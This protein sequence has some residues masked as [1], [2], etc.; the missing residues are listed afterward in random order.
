MR[1]NGPSPSPEDIFRAL[2]RHDSEADELTL[3]RNRV[4]AIVRLA[5]DAAHA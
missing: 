5:Q 2:S 3:S 1:V 4:S